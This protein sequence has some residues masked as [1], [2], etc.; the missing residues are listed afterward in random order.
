MR[1]RFFCLG[2]CVSTG[3]SLGAWSLPARALT[4]PD[5]T[6]I[7]TDTEVQDELTLLGETIDPSTDAAITP[8]TFRP[9]CNLTFTVLRRLTD[10]RNSFGWYNV[11]GEVPTLDQ[12][13]EFIHCDDPPYTW[14]QGDQTS[15][16]PND[17][18]GFAAWLAA[19]TV[20]G[21]DRSRSAP[22]PTLVTALR[23]FVAMASGS[24]GFP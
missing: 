15:R 20:A 2:V 11:T 5:G 19:P 14:Q 10:Y 24:Q 13:H 22:A 1:A 18:G 6:Q 21:R 3:L 7:P 17:R 4:Q 9:Q 8:Q 12:L 23:C 16:V